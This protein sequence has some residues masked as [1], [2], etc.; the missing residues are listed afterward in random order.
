[1]KMRRLSLAFLVVSSLLASP[2]DARAQSSPDTCTPDPGYTSC[3]R[4]RYNGNDLGLATTLTPGTDQQFTVPY[5]V[6]SIRVK[7]WGAGGGGAI[8]GGFGAP[9]GSGGYVEA[10]LAVTPGALYTVMVG[11]GGSGDGTSGNAIGNF[12]CAAAYG[13]G[14]ACAIRSNHVDGGG[15]GGLAGL[16]TG[17]AL[18]TASDL[19]RAVLIAG[20]GG[21]GESSSG[22]SPGNAAGGAGG[23]PDGPTIRRL[24]TMKGV[25]G[26]SLTTPPQNTGGGGGYH[27]GD[28]SERLDDSIGCIRSAE[29][30]SNFIL[31]DPIVTPIA[32]ESGNEAS[33]VS[34]PNQ[35]KQAAPHDNALQYI[36]Y[37]TRAVNVTVG[38]G[39]GN[40]AANQRGGN[41]LVVI[42]WVDQADLWI[43][44]TDNRTAY[45]PG[46]NLAYTIVVG[47]DGPTNVSGALVNDPL[48]AGITTASWTCGSGTNGGTCGAASGSGAISNA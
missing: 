1:M 39:V 35:N 15:G 44:K 36:T 30:G 38:A 26:V 20:G 8:A 4:Y 40:N 14:G 21:A 32:N 34:L 23:K 24:S 6:S 45:V 37:P 17:T 16:F 18:V 42:Q 12:L 28:W 31:T 19:A 9:G 33:R 47:N 10:T 5:N 25:D 29:G 41:G 22:C 48:P 7:A 46:D 11:G 13:F 2:P 3:V 43:T 27:G